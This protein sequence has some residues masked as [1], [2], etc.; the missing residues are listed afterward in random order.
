[1]NRNTAKV[2]VFGVTMAATAVL[3]LAML[4]PAPLVAYDTGD[5]KADPGPVMINGL[6]ISVAMADTPRRGDKLTVCV[7]AD[8]DT[9]ALVRGQFTVLLVRTP[10][11][12]P[13][14]RMEGAPILEAQQ[15]RTM[16]VSANRGETVEVTFNKKL[17]AGMYD[18]R[19]ISAADAAKQQKGSRLT[20]PPDAV[21]V[22][23]FAVAKK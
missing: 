13:H 4:W 15:M 22:A 18:V 12:D 6:A 8:N 2:V 17:Q 14:S 5:A 20:I 21:S 16:Q 7:Q 3:T 11:S 10:E 23:S 9:D 19:V 1:M